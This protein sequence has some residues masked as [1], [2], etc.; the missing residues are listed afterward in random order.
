MFEKLYNNQGEI[1]K[2]LL[3]VVPCNLCGEDQTTYWGEKFGLKIMECVSCGLIYVKHRLNS[4]GRQLAYAEDYFS[5]QSDDDDSR[6]RT[7]MYLLEIDDLER[8]IKNGQI[9]DVGAGGGHFLSALGKQWEKHGCEIND[10]AASYGRN[11][12]NLDIK[13]GDLESIEY[14]AG[15]FDCINFRGVI[16]HLPD[17]LGNLKKAY[18]FLKP[19]GIV[20][21]NT[22]N[23]ASLC[24]RL[25][26]EGFRLVDPRFH[27]YYFSPKTI[28][29]I[30]EKAS[31]SVLRESYFYLDT[32]YANPIEDLSKIVKDLTLKQ[33]NPDYKAESPPFFEN[34][35]NIYA[36]KKI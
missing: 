30:L 15:Y 14:P 27:I 9:L 11:H 4:I 20:S 22:P 32:P 33:T 7:Q 19:R 26:K 28:R 34:V 21:I 5:L 31:F 23:I 2:N 13:T 17:P 16:E 18:Q 36:L 3:E 35:I 25:Y 8:T 10:I 24:A 6:K 12:Y 1:L 29:M